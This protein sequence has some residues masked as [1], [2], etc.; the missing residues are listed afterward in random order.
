VIAVTGAGQ[1]GVATATM[2]ARMGLEFTIYMGAVDVERQSPNV[3]WMEQLGAKVVRV[4]F[5]TKRLKDAVMGALQ[6]YLQNYSDSYYLL[7]SA[8]GPHPFP[9]MVKDFQSIIGLE[10]R[11][12]MMKAE[13]R[14]PDYVIACIGGGSNAI[15]A[16]N[17]FL[18]EKEVKLVAVEA[19]GRDINKIGEHASR[20]QGSG[21]LGVI[22]GFK[23][24]FITD[25]DGQMQ[26]T[27]SI[28]AGLDYSGIGPEHA[29]LFEKKRV[30]YTYAY[31]KEVISAF[32]MLAR[33]EGIFAA[34]ESSHAVAEAV[35]LAPTLSKNKII[36]VNISGRG[37]KDIFT[38]AEAINDSSWKQ[39]IIDRA[40]SYKR[41][42]K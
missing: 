20:I 25:N 39:Y 30:T 41:I 6:D 31:D 15:G 29:Q 24:F 7:G 26:N 36:I 13:K 32:Q 5:G 21:S 17:A 38:V 35:R 42:K 2:A 40:E 22:E 3:F 12:Q 23:S 9:S 14:L 34:L 18:D 10:A 27:H 33:N 8:L 16:F 28:S 19:G 11:E 1:H 4:E 37:D